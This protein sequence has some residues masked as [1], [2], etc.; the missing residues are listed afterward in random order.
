MKPITKKR[1]ALFR[2]YSL[3]GSTSIEDSQAL[4]TASLDEEADDE[5]KTGN[6]GNTT[7]MRKLA[8]RA[9]VCLSRHSGRSLSA[10]NAGNLTQRTWPTRC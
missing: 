6:V 1:T 3:D 2:Q 5:N 10:S 7:E 9:T 4:S 8:A